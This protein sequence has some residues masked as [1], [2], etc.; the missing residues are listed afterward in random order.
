MT[1]LYLLL[2]LAVSGLLA[3]WISPDMLRWV[4]FRLLARADGIEAYRDAR[5]TTIDR[6]TLAAREDQHA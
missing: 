4:A 6:W 2:P 1:F 3:V 5:Q